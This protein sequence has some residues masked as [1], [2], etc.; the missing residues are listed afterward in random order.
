MICHDGR[1]ETDKGKNNEAHHSTRNQEH[2]E[3]RI[4][5][6]LSQPIEGAIPKRIRGSPD[7]PVGRQYVTETGS[8]LGIQL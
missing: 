4:A 1:G 8:L 3:N 5:E 7:Q 2:D 6:F